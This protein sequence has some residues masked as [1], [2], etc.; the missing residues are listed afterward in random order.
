MS[1]LAPEFSGRVALVTGGARGI[2][3]ACCL[4]LA[5]GGARIALNYATNHEAALE[6]KAM[7]AAAGGVC[8]L[9][10]ADVGD[11]SAFAAA[12][13]S[14]RD[15]FGPITLFVAN[16]GTTK[17]IGHSDLTLDILRETLRVNL[18]GVFIGIQQVKSDMIAQGGGSIVCL[19][20]IAAFRPRARQIDYAAAKA[21]VVAMVRCYAEALA[22]DVRVNAVA[23]GLTETDMIAGL[24]QNLLPS[25]R[26]AIPLKR[27]G[28]PE[29]IAEAVAFLLSDRAAF[30]TGHT[31]VVSGGDVMEP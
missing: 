28:Q 8:E 17:A 5:A 14:A 25:R 19:S 20:S 23:P 30:V 4:R 31:L 10:P 12:V 22:P 1:E 16:A 7:I 6:T 13:T 15:K 26:A 9:F 18:E 29:E 3:R 24:D 11:E 21:G 27:F 2:G